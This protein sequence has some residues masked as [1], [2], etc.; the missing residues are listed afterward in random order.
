MIGVQRETVEGDVRADSCNAGP[1]T[2][3]E[4]LVT[5]KACLK[6]SKACPRRYGMYARGFREVP[7]AA[8]PEMDATS[9]SIHFHVLC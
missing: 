9:S 4:P 5:V 3:T 8:T 1:A 6:S 2:G 7:T